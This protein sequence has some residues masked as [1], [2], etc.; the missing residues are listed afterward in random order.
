LSSEPY[1]GQTTDKKV[2]EEMKK[3]YY[4]TIGWDEQGIP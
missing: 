3:N 1:E 4:D 2:V